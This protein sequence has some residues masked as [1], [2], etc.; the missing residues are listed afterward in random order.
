[1]SIRIHVPNRRNIKVNIFTILYYN[2]LQDIYKTTFF[3]YFTYMI[4]NM[5]TFSRSCD[6][7]TLVPDRYE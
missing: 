5:Y 7:F 6:V 4:Y 1:M 3:E 2:I